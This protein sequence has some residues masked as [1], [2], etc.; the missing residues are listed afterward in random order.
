MARKGLKLSLGI[1]IVL[2]LG[3]LIVLFKQPSRS[4]NNKTQ[5]ITV[6]QTATKSR[7]VSKKTEAKQPS[8][9]ISSQTNHSQTTAVTAQA[10]PIT[11]DN[12]ATTKQSRNA[13]TIQA[14]PQAALGTWK[15][16]SPQANEVTFTV[17]ADGSIHSQADFKT[18]DTQI[19]E[20]SAT[21]SGVKEVA[22]NKYVWVF[23]GGN[24][25]ALLPGV[26]GIGGVGKTE[27]GF[28]LNN[29]QLTPVLFLESQDGQVDYNNM[30]TYQV[31]LSR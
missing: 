11:E 14:I 26:T 29:G 21:V 8:Q 19:D 27:T 20:A 24:S 2:I 6:S 9:A 10:N 22:P 31:E 25:A 28:I 17:G 18:D 30:Q 13:Q 7:K 3:I 4:K 5:Q 16:R 23:S 15:G 12:Q 1:L